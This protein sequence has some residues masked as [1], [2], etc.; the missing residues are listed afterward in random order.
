MVFDRLNTET[1]TEWMR[2]D[3]RSVLPGMAVQ[4]KTPTAQSFRAKTEKGQHFWVRGWFFGGGCVELVV[5]FDWFY[6]DLERSYLT[7]R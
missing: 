2:R 1:W 6:R 4:K 5:P 7:L 3:L